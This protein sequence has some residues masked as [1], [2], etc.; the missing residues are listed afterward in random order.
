MDK[1]TYP[2][3]WSTGVITPIF[4]KGDRTFPKN[5]RGITLLPIMGKIFTKILRERL[6]HWAETND[7]LNEAQFGFRPN[8]RTTDPILILTTHDCCKDYHTVR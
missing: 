4:K 8:R 1:E 5:Y 6:L 3:N 2:E 7:L